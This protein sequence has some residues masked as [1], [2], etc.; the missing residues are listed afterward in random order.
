[1]VLPF[2]LTMVWGNNYTLWFK[3]LNNK[4]MSCKF[5]LHYKVRTNKKA[6]YSAYANAMY[7]LFQEQLLSENMS[8]S[9]KNQ[10]D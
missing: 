4:Y 5:S 3:Y 1:M 9:Q 2:P 8:K 7:I 10:I 6:S